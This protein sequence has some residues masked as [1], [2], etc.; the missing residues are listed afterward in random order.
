MSAQVQP[1]VRSVSQKAAPRFISLQE[2][3]ARVGISRSTICRLQKA[4]AF[5]S[6]IKLSARRLGWLESDVERWIGWRTMEGR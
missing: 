1:R 5:P 3:V 4:G 2:V 6:S